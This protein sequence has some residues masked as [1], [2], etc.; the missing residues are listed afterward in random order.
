V[1]AGDGAAVGAEP[2]GS[3]AKCAL[4][5]RR[6]PPGLLKEI[7]IPAPKGEAQC[8]GILSG[9]GTVSTLVW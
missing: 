8:G 2:P 3:G 9:A 6:G 1:T 5:V 7:A 4:P